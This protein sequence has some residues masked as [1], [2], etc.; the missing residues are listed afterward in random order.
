MATDKIHTG[1]VITEDGMV[2]AQLPSRNRWGF[3]L[4]DDDQ[5]WPGG[6]GIASEWEPI[7]DNDSRIDDAT[8]DRL[9]CLID[10]ARTPE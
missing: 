1:Y 8:R 4:A 3:I 10:E 6:F 5:S 7:D 9:Q 2:L